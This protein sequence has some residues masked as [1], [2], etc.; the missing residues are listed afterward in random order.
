VFCKAQNIDLYGDSQT[1]SANLADL[2]W[3]SEQTLEITALNS[4]N[5]W[6]RSLSWKNVQHHHLVL[7]ISS[8]ILW[9]EWRRPRMILP[10]VAAGK[11][12]NLEYGNLES[13][14]ENFYLKL[15]LN[16]VLVR[17]V[18]G[19][20]VLKRGWEVMWVWL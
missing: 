6:T 15:F 19:L 10:F 18:G 13:N 5:I 11:V 14:L 1:A 3:S 17:G 9:Q 7:E 8:W 16:L 2:Q 20:C 12:I 4:T